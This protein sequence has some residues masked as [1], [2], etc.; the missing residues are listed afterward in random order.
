[1]YTGGKWNDIYSNYT[2]NGYIIEYNVPE[3][4]TIVFFLAT[5]GILAVQKILKK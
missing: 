1:M 4:N 5:L 3:M 2:R